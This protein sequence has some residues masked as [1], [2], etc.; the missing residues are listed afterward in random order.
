MRSRSLQTRSII[1]I[2]I[3]LFCSSVMTERAFGDDYTIYAA[4]YKTY[5]TTYEDILKM[6]LRV[7]PAQCREQSRRRHDLYNELMYA[8]L[9]PHY[10]EGV[11]TPEYD[12]LDDAGKAAKRKEL[13]EK[14]LQHMKSKVGYSIQDINGD[15]VEELLIGCDKSY[16][17]ELF[18]IE[19]GKVRELIKAGYRYSCHLLN[20]GS[21]FRFVSDGGDFYGGVLFQMQGTGQ[22]RF[23]EGYYYNGQ[24]GYENNLDDDDCWFKITDAKNFSAN[25]MDQHVPSS[26]ANTWISQCESKYANIGFI[27]FAAYEKGVSGEGIAILSVNGKTS[28]SQKVRIRT[29]ASNKSKILVQ[30]KVG[31]YVKAIGTDGDY[32]QVEVDNKTGYVQKDF[33]TII[34]D[35][36]ESS[37]KE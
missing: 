31:T 7:M 28:G 12:R 30:K 19:D 24:L 16:I 2:W 37:V 6:Y 1:L 5:D 33:I 27:P 35:L 36:P 34:T 4:S 25:T 17:Y 14:T 15:G 22:V 9:S 13:Q 10:M 18:T 23:V 21:L 20:D 11:M 3:F 8:D 26:E 32:Y 29:K